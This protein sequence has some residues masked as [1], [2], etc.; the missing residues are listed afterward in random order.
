VR[1]L[2]LESEPSLS[3]WKS[4][5]QIAID[6]EGEKHGLNADVNRPTLCT[7]ENHHVKLP[8]AQAQQQTNLPRKSM[9]LVRAAQEAR[10]AKLLAAPVV[11]AVGAEVAE[12]EEADGAFGDANDTGGE[13]GEDSAMALAAPPAVA[14]PPVDAGMKEVM[15]ARRRRQ[16]ATDGAGAT[17]AGVVMQTVADEA[18]EALLCDLMAA[19]GVRAA[20]GIHADRNGLIAADS[21][22]ARQAWLTVAGE[23]RRVLELASDAAAADDAQ[24]IAR[25]QYDDLSAQY[26]FMR[27]D[28]TDDERVELEDELD[29]LHACLHRS[30]TEG[31]SPNALLLNS[32]LVWQQAIAAMGRLDEEGTACAPFVFKLYKMIQSLYTRVQAL[33]EEAD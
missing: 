13:D 5:G 15:E 12:E 16:V 14:P 27:D 10:R 11:E 4:R 9:E 32:L 2:S 8:V 24:C 18:T 6:R 17:C 20:A 25:G 30:P 33:D 3:W 26:E 29:E 7:A 22:A 19:A 28:L 31:P 23:T 1:V 21:V